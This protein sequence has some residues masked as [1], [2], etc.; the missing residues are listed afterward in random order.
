MLNKPGHIDLTN[1]TLS[2]P[3]V[4][5]AI[6]EAKITSNVIGKNIIDN[7]QLAGVYTLEQFEF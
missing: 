5:I 7:R 4:V 6:G 3:E 2:L 1:D